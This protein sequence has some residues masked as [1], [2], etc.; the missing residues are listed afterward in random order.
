MLWK[1]TKALKEV[2]KAVK[3]IEEL[4]ADVS[5][6]KGK[7]GGRKCR[8]LMEGAARRGGEGTGGEKETKAMKEFTKAV[9]HIQ[10]M[11]AGM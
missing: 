3:H 1:E 4:Q 10:V 2:T 9:K 5:C 7:G 11:Q 6:G 8:G